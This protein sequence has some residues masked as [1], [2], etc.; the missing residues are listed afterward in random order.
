MEIGDRVQRKGQTFCG[1]VRD[2][3]HPS[4]GLVRL[5]QVHWG[6]KTMHEGRAGMEMLD[7]IPEPELEPYPHE[8]VSADEIAARTLAQWEREIKRS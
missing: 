1:I 4:P 5:I 7:W 3:D 2:V 8:V 6:T